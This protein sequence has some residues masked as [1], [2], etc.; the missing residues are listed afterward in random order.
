LKRFSVPSIRQIAFATITALLIDASE[1]LVSILADK[2]YV[3]ELVGILKKK[4]VE[5]NPQ[6]APLVLKLVSTL[7]SSPKAKEVFVKEYGAAFEE[8]WKKLSSDGNGKDLAE[9]L[10]KLL[11]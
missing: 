3:S 10:A 6:S 4:E 9:P 1:E 11:Q 8:D 5:V 2:G 7:T